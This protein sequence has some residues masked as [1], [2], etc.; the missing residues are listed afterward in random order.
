M[1]A[2]TTIFK[3]TTDLAE[4]IKFAKNM[5]KQSNVIN[6]LKEVNNQYFDPAGIRM[7]FDNKE[8]PRLMYQTDVENIEKSGI[9]SEKSIRMVLTCD[10]ASRNHQIELA[11]ECNGIVININ[12][13]DILSYPPA[14]LSFNMQK[15]T[16]LDCFKTKMYEIYYA[17]FGTVTTL[18]Y[19]DNKWQLS[20][21]NSYEIDNMIWL[22]KKTFREL[23]DELFASIELDINKLDTNLCYSF[24][25]H[26]NEY[27]KFNGATQKP[28]RGWF[29]RAIN[30]TK[31]NGENNESADYH[32]NSENMT[33]NNN[34]FFNKMPK[35]QEATDI[36]KI[37]SAD[38]E[39]A[40]KK[41]D[42]KCNEALLKYFNNPKCI[43]C[44]GFI[45][46]S[47]KPEI[48]ADVLI[49]STLQTKLRQL[50]GQ[51]PP[52]DIPPEDRFQWM[53]IN[54]SFSIEYRPVFKSLFP[55]TNNSI[56]KLD[57][58]M[59]KVASRVTD[60]YGKE[61]FKFA[62]NNIDKVAEYVLEQMTNDKILI[63]RQVSSIR[64]VQDYL[65]QSLFIP[66]LL[67]LMV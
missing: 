20:T 32:L 22:G 50:I 24:G 43:P 12:T 31:F 41:I 1:R 48:I 3:K 23:I 14:A 65:C 10:R 39:A 21:A 56:D 55:Q 17:D 8:I 62:D 27:H 13:W 35:Q 64:I 54:S 59:R 16:I 51:R 42:E 44:Y 46:K 6:V 26:H 33:T 67:K 45:L 36:I 2:Q 15:S 5:I 28:V 30:L 49:E 29:I 34:V 19:F 66:V 58:I 61:N 57:E 40:L 37:L 53:M 4:V 25:F 60:A 47:V 11:S 9:L 7:I 63:N 38:P 52:T 18:Y